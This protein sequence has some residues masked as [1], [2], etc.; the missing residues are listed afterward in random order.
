VRMARFATLA[1]VLA[2]AVPARGQMI[3]GFGQ[4]T[5]GGNG[6]PVYYVTTLAD[7]GPTRSPIPGSLRAALTGGNR[8]VRF[9]VSG[10]LALLRDLEV[11]HPN[12]TIDGSTAPNGGVALLRYAL[13]INADNVAVR[14][15]RFRGSHPSEAHDGISIGGGNNILIDHVSCSW[16]TDE[17]IS[18]YGYSFT[19]LGRVRNIT[20]QNSL[21]AEA[22]EGP[23]SAALVDGD[24]SEVTW[25]RNVFAK[26][27]DR[28]P[29]LASGR[30][31]GAHGDPG[32]PLSG[33]GRYELIQNVIYDAIYGTR[34]WNQSPSWTIE[35]D[36]VG[37]VWIPGPRWPRPKIPIQIFA[38]PRSEGPIRVYLDANAGPARPN[39]LG[40]TCDQ[41]S[42]EEFDTPC[43]GWHWGHDLRTRAT[44]SHGFPPTNPG[45]LLDVLLPE[46][47]ATLPCR[48][49]ADRRILYEVRSRTGA[50]VRGPG[51]LPDLSARCAG[52][53]TVADR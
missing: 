43:A 29:Q 38:S 18:L 11:K 2:L 26:N 28:N 8:I 17:C 51:A 16:P 15:L 35:L 31:R 34:I 23:Y 3:I 36:A 24:V 20:I 30:R 41:F 19:G 52:S 49:S 21:F 47:G 48:D 6:F 14:Y 13:T 42:L 46:I 22:P 9:R 12:V 10:N 53:L 1:V 45:I 44:P 32:V 50:R 7:Y 4:Q 33:V 37:N 27:A 40:R 5:T 25:Y 39:A